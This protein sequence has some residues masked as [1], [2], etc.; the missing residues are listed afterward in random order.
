MMYKLVDK[1][2]PVLK[3]KCVPFDFNNP[4]M[5]PLELAAAMKDLMVK[6]RGVGLS[7]NQIG[8]PYRVFVIGD[9]T[10]PD[11]I[12]EVFNPRIV[13]ESD[14]QNV[15]EE[16]CL[17]FPG[18][19]LKVKRPALI[20]ARYANAHG[21]VDTHVFDKIPARVF[22]HEYD[23]MEGVVFTDRV[24]KVT[25]QRGLQQKAKLDRRR[26]RNMANGKVA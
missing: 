22:L 23:H 19:F 10:D 13:F 26:K 5:D 25:L 6:N 9:P 14:E 2:D 3:Q 20:R 16:G 18:L 8:L 4:P 12:A 15:I 1:N 17:S 24:G 7:A 11:N 21:K